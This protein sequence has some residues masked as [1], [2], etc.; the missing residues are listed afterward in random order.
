[1]IGR[2]KKRRGEKS[3]ISAAIILTSML[4]VTTMLLFSM[5]SHYKSLNELSE[6]NMILRTYLLRTETK[7]Y[8]TEGEVTALVKEL[9]E[10]GVTNV[11]LSG[12]FSPEV[13][14]NIQRN[15]GKAMFGEEVLLR[16]EGDIVFILPEA[17]EKTYYF[18]QQEVKHIDIEKR[19]VASQ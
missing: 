17:D 8:L 6:V 2:I 16:V 5:S 19:G 12:N 11:K 10:S 4:A 3:V 9:Q 7:G 13:T 18:L 14:R 1:M 15:Y